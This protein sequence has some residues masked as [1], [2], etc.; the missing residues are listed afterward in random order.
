M[1]SDRIIAFFESKGF[2]VKL[3]SNPNEIRIN[4]PF[5]HLQGKAPDTKY[6]LYVNVKEGLVHCFRC[7]YGNV[8]GR[9]LKDLK[10]SLGDWKELGYLR[11]GRLTKTLGY[12]SALQ[13]KLPFPKIDEIS[14]T[15]RKFYIQFLKKRN[16]DEEVIWRYDLRVGVDKYKDRIIIPCKE[17]F[18]DI[19]F[20]SRRIFETNTTKYRN[21]GKGEFGI[22]IGKSE[23]VYNIDNVPKESDVVVVME[24][25][26]DVISTHLKP[27]PSV[28]ILGKTISKHQLYKILLKKPRKVLVVLDSDAHRETLQIAKFLSKYVETEALLLKTGD[29]GELGSRY[30]KEGDKVRVSPLDDR[31]TSINLLK[32]KGTPLVERNSRNI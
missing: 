32:W 4:C 3:T 15:I 11:Y 5:C 23:V 28:A 30:L 12:T 31:V 27:Y 2:T 20:T 13:V 26:F 25:P 22:L 24:G 19:Y 16:L 29:P 9:F 7:G 6:H 17:N 1:R 14:P 10:L 21:P 18:V 8:L